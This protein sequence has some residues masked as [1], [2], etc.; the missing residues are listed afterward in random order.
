MHTSTE[1][2]RLMCAVRAAEPADPLD[3]V[4][5]LAAS[6]RLGHASPPTARHVVAR[7]RYMSGRRHRRRVEPTDD[8]KQLELQGR[9]PTL[10][11]AP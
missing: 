2:L 4:G 6:P 3:R 9:L 11:V 10:T 1:T 7:G 8:W 5:R